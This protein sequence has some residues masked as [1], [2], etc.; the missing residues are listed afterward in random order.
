MSNVAAKPLPA[1]P[2]RSDASTYWTV[3]VLAGLLALVVVTRWPSHAAEVID[4]DESTFLIT[5]QDILRG[6]LPYLV[7]FDNKPPGMSLVLAGAL[8]LF[9]PTVLAA[10]LLADACVL[11]LAA[12]VYF[13]GRR[14]MGRL[15]AFALAAGL[16]TAFSG[17]YARY[18]SS[19]LVAAVPLL[20][21][22]A[23]LLRSS[24]KVWCSPAVGLLLSLATLVRTNLGFVALAVGVLHL[25][26]TARPGWPRRDA[27]VGYIV[28]GLVPPLFLV[29]VYAAA[30]H[31]D[32]LWAGLVAV[33]LSYE[34][35]GRGLLN[36]LFWLQFDLFALGNVWISLFVVLLVAGLIAFLVRL[37]R[38]SDDAEW[39]RDAVVILVV[40]S[41]TLASTLVGGG[42]ES[43]YLAQLFPLAALALPLAVA[44]T[45]WWKRAA[46]GAAT[47]SVAGVTALATPPLIAS[48]GAVA[49]GRAAV[50]P[51]EMAATAIDADRKPSDEVWALDH[52]LV[53][54]YL[55]MPPVVPL[56][57]HPDNIFRPEIAGPLVRAGLA[58]T[59]VVGAII[60]RS[61]RYVVSAG[62]QGTGFETAADQTRID[63]LLAGYD[64]WYDMDG[65]VI[66]RRR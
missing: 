60:A 65:I 49:S 61:P 16:V 46:L 15:L 5:A 7:T 55:D 38:G 57:T 40:F 27:L 39:R 59:D 14:Y 66:Y 12:M 45:R 34:A 36:A 42:F 62:M 10:R 4:W 41:A 24:D 56:A 31:L 43:H 32:L 2:V 37:I 64:R 54:F 23:L 11:T 33:P 20:A 44:S 29:V 28:A 6:H 21:A 50:H 18:A 26:A 1:Q 9:G 17:T 8:I 22:A 63:A 53:L 3:L 47:F 35:S 48:V 13:S 30:G 58:P 25:V 19:E 52:Q 51:I